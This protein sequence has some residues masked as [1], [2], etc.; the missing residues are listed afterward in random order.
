LTQSQRKQ[1][2]ASLSKGSFKTS[3]HNSH[4]SHRSAKVSLC[5]NASHF[6]GSIQT[7]DVQGQIQGGGHGSHVAV[8][9]CFTG[10]VHAEYQIFTCN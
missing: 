10:S 9:A 4:G 6:K 2:S 1:R 7:C 3:W 5:G 8:D